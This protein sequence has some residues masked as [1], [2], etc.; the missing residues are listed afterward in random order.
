LSGIS[1]NAGRVACRQELIEL[2]RRRKRPL[3]RE[4]RNPD[5]PLR[6]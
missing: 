1:A 4:L 3:L 2:V 6:Q 5:D